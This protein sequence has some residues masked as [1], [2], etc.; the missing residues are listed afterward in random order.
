MTTSKSPE[1]GGDKA[2]IQ[3]TG[4]EPLLKGVNSRVVVDRRTAY[5]A[6]NITALLDAMDTSQQMRI[7]QW[8]VQVAVR[9]A[10][11]VLPIFEDAIPDDQRPRLAV[12]AAQHWLEVSTEAATKAARQAANDAGSASRVKLVNTLTTVPK[13]AWAA[14]SAYFAA[15][16]A[17]GAVQ[18]N[19][20]GYYA[21]SAVQA[22]AGACG[23]DPDEVPIKE[24]F[25]N[26]M[27]RAAYI[28]LYRSGKL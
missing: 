4:R 6:G 18:R 8:A 2:Q 21:A 11:K 7:K 12:K 16:A 17:S 26:A 28:I 1:L 10:Y 25:S 3:L 9:R 15:L 20:A 5:L 14:R 22:A 19:F 27:L 24:S 13:E 23:I